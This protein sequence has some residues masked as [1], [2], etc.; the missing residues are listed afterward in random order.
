MKL[1]TKLSIALHCLVFILE[2]QNLTKVTS[3]LLGKS[4]G[5]NAAAVRNILGVLQKAG[6][7]YISRGIGGAHL[8]CDPKKLTVWQIYEALESKGL[9]SFI[10]IHTKPFEGC[11]VGNNI[12]EVLKEP[13]DR[14][15]NAMMDTMKT[16][17]IY[18]L[19]ESYSRI[20]GRE[21]DN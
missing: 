9:S 20:I 7:I 21:K 13:Y 11:P 16:I 2:Y 17:T 1:S 12:R 6:F 15:G 8:S 18:D 4:T 19:W 14:I 3:E 5:C 10:G